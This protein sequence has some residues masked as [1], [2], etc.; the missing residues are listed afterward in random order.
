MKTLS[1]LTALAMAAAMALSLTACTVGGDTGGPT[2]TSPSP[3]QSGGTQGNSPAPSASR[4]AEDASYL[5]GIC[6]L[7]PHDALDAATQGFKDA[8]TEELGDQVKFSEG[9]AGGDSNNCI[10]IIDGFLSEDV[11]LILANATASLTAAASATDTVPILGTAITNYGVALNL[12]STEDGVL[13]GNISGTSDLAPL[14][15]QA[16]LLQELF[17][18]ADYPSVGLLY[19][20]A[21]PNSIFQV[22]TIQGYLEE[23]G[24]TCA[25]YAFTDVNDLASVTQTACD[26]SD[27]I[28]IPTDNTAANNTE[29]IAN[30]VIPAGVPVVA[31]ESGICSGCGV[32]TLSIDYYELGE[33]TGN[34]AARILTGEESVSE[35]AIAYDTTLT[36][37]YNPANCEALGITVPED[38]EPLA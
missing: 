30:V 23:I 33:I 12:D 20:S 15:Q 25:Q 35:M 19:C 17:P 1:K 38:Y 21:D 16:E 28:Y 11:D 13:G 37:L 8:L 6:Q 27:V 4:P 10:T 14:D 31:G 34:M 36:K 2:Q 3:S 5:V 22:E 29:T 7:A 9:N 24:Y 32:A 26:S 18:A